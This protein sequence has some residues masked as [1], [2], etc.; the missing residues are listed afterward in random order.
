MGIAYCSF[1]F[2]MKSSFSKCPGAFSQKNNTI[3]SPQVFLFGWLY[4]IWKFA[5]IMRSPRR[6]KEKQQQKAHLKHGVQCKKGIRATFGGRIWSHPTVRIREKKTSLRKG[7]VKKPTV[8]CLKFAD[9]QRVHILT[10]DWWITLYSG[11]IFWRKTLLKAI[12]FAA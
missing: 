7:G 5:G 10:L 1:F 6:K 8:S 2:F 3:R 11:T 4:L 12:F 9:R